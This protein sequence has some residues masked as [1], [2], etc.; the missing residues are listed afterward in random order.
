MSKKPK[1][2]GNYPKLSE[3]ETE[4]MAVI[5][6]GEGQ[7]TS[8]YIHDHITGHTWTLSTVMTMLGRLCK[9][10]YVQCDRSTRTNYYTAVISEKD[11]RAQ[12]S[13]EFLEKMHGNS[14]DGM[15]T[16][17]YNSGAISDKEFEGLR[18]AVL[19]QD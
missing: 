1:E 18:K 11:Y 17:L 9:K 15:I 8:N 3:A 14:V 5:W 4:I 16:A 6:A 19:D 12:A 2:D 13:K 10:G 7:L